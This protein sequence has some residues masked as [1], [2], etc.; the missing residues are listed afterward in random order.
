MKKLDLNTLGGQSTIEQT[1]L[2]ATGGETSRRR[3]AVEQYY[4]AQ[5]LQFD[6]MEK[7][8]GKSLL[9]IEQRQVV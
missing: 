8:Q 2:P 3:R 5:Q 4:S 1:T 7:N 9:N 6:Q